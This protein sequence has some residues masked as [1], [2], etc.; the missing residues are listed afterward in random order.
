MACKGTWGGC[1]AKLPPQQGIPP[2]A[3]R[4]SARNAKLCKALLE[5]IREA[6]AENGCPRSQG[7]LL[8]T[9]STKVWADGR[10][11]GIA[12]LRAA[13]RVLFGSLLSNGAR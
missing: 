8:Y 2:G 7:Q 1:G 3:F 6:G 4:D 10:A 11:L 5:V 13:G 12:S 9:C